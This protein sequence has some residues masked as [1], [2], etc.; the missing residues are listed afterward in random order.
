MKKLFT[1]L[2]ILPF[3]FSCS[4]DD[5]ER[6]IEP[7]QDYTSFVF[8][9]D[10]NVPFENCIAAYLDDNKHYIKIADLGTIEPN[11]PSKEVKLENN[12]ITSVYL[13]TDYNSV[14]RFNKAFELKKNKKNSFDLYGVSGIKI[15]DKKDPTQYPQ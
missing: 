15:E 3:V 6:A 9:Q 1:L 10:A 7:T 14:I 5:N 4:S 8:T 11:K 12:D 2:L 13:F